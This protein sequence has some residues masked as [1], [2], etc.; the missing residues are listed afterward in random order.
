[1]SMLTDAEIAQLRTD[2][3]ETLPDT[4]NILRTTWS[5]NKG[6]MVPSE[7]TAVS[8]AACRVDPYNKQDS[9]GMLAEQESNRSYFRL[10]VAYDTDLQDG[11]TLSFGG[12]RYEVLQLYDVHSLRIVKRAM[13]ARVKPEG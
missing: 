9:E 10:T 8:G 13:L 6:T 2:V 1:M 7:S 4:C 5:N 3:L 12:E 11:D